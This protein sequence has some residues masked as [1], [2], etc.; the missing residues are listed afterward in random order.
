MSLSSINTTPSHCAM[1]CGGGNN[2]VKTLSN[3][4]SPVILTGG[5]RRKKRN[6]AT[7]KRER[8]FSD[9]DCPVQQKSYC[10]TYHKIDKGNGAKAKYDLSTESHLHGWGSKLAARVFNM[11]TN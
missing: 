3:F 4:H 2:F 10:N 9:V 8:E 6:L 5:M 7:K 11:N 1:Q